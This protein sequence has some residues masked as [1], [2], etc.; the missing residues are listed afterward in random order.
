M[1]MQNQQVL[2]RDENQR[3]QNQS[4]DLPFLQVKAE[5]LRHQEWLRNHAL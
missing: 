1:Q 4:I 3:C 5:S 2:L